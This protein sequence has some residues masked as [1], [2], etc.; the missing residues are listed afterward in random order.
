MSSNY[1]VKYQLHG[2]GHCSDTIAAISKDDAMTKV[3]GPIVAK[4]G[5]EILKEEHLFHVKIL[6]SHLKAIHET[7]LTQG[8]FDKDDV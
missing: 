1:L 5:K 4:Y 6:A 8:D 2:F 7:A 3:V